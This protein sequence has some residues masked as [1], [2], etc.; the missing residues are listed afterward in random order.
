MGIRA[1]GPDP[2]PRWSPVILS[3]S[4]TSH[5]GFKLHLRASE[6]GV[7]GVFGVIAPLFNPPSVFFCLFFAEGK[8]GLISSEASTEG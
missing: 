8:F 3:D 1:A 2:V 6:L 7:G 4:K 5:L